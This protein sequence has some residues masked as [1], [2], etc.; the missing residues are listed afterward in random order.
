M[1]SFVFKASSFISKN[2]Y[3]VDQRF[4]FLLGDK[5]PSRKEAIDLETVV[6]TSYSWLLQQHATDKRGDDIPRYDMYV[7]L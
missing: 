5:S 6:S 1:F 7:Y 3:L 2:I 4:Y